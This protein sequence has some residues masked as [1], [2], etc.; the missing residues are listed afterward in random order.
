MVCDEMAAPVG[1]LP[2]AVDGQ[3]VG[4]HEHAAVGFGDEPLPEL[5]HHGIQF[6]GT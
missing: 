4:F 2:I 3:E 1:H 6:Y 5:C